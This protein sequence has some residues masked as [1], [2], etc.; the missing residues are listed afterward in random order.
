MGFAYITYKQGNLFTHGSTID[1]LTNY[2]DNV[3]TPK[4]FSREERMEISAS[5]IGSSCDQAI[6]GLEL[7]QMQ[8]WGNEEQSE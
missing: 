7:L 8:I 6:F 3:L 5:N 1:G 4:F 2:H